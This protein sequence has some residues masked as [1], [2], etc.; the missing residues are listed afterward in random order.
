MTALGGV[1]VVDL[2]RLLPGAFASRELLR[3][4]A[5]V[6][7]VEPP[8]GDGLRLV[9]PAWHDSLNGGKESVAVDLRGEPRLALELCR[10][11][12]VVLE[13]F[14]PGVAARLGLEPGERT[15]WV[16]ITGFGSGGRHEQRAG[17]DLNYLGWA[18]VL[19]DVVPP[20]TIADFAGAYAAVREALA[21]LLERARTG[22]GGR[23]E[24][25]MTHE[26]Y[27]LAVPGILRGDAAC[28]R[29]YRTADGRL[30][31]VAALEAKFWRRL[32]ELVGLPE[33]EARAFEPRLPELEDR[34]AERSLADWIELFDGE[35]VCA[36]PVSSHEE[37]ALDFAASPAA[38]AAHVGEHTDAWLRELGP[39]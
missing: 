11:A 36:G 15:V 24:V 7:R 30:L 28:Y 31:T 37:A 33:L 5:R 35:D 23:R 32:C 27:E 3:L 2:T 26:S 1:L 19:G 4:G 39:S 9:D 20:V 29:L 16:S 22:R 12:D 21:G 10:A 6:V 17:H 18:G 14:R 34:L 8:E 25:S 38:P 13:G